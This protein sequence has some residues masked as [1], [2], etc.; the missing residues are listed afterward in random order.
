MQEP[1]TGG[2][3][4]PART[5]G[6]A[7]ASRKYDALWVY[8]VGPVLGTLSGTMSYRFIRMTEKQPPQSLP[9]MGSSTT[10]KSPSTSL[11]LRR[12]QSQEMARPAHVNPFGY[13]MGEHLVLYV[14][15]VIT[16]KTGAQRIESANSSGLEATHGLARSARCTSAV[17]SIIEKDGKEESSVGEE[18]EPLL[19]IVECRICQEEDH[20]KNL[21]TPCSCSGSIKYAHRGC[22]QRW[23]NEKGDITC[24]ICNEQY[25][26]GYTVVPRVPPV[27][28]VI[29]ISGGWTIRGSHL[30]LHDPRVIAMAT[31][32]H[33][34]LEA[35]YDEQAATNVSSVACSF[36]VL[37]LMA[38]LLLRQALSITDAIEED[39]DDDAS[40][41]FSLFLL[42]AVSFLFPCYIM[43]WTI[44]VLQRRRER[45]E[46]AAL[47]SATEVASM[48]Q[49]SG[50]GRH[51]QF[52]TAPESPSTLEQETR[53]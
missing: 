10:P 4:N 29:N 8:F 40:T 48:L 36:V 3:M 34:F 38:L 26:P 52:A 15:E 47:L 1:I 45:Q 41:Y 6:P 39:D 46:A 51:L 11:K 37:L 44:S 22:V 17:D 25:R 31:A 19:Q 50:Q 43:A 32:R 14:D 53:R 30:D 42:R 16:P 18:E 7:V 5:L 21:E 9:S 33:G 12:L 35:E 27:E 24:E 28:S 20:I 49:Q 2:S 23:C 13:T